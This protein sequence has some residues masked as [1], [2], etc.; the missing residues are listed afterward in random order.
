MERQERACTA[1]RSINSSQ[2]DNMDIENVF[3]RLQNQ[4]FNRALS[5]I[6]CTE[7][8]VDVL[9][10]QSHDVRQAIADL[11]NIHACNGIEDR[12]KVWLDNSRIKLNVQRELAQFPV[13]IFPATKKDSG[14]L[15]GLKP[16]VGPNQGL[17][18]RKVAHEYKLSEVSLSTIKGYSPGSKS[19]QGG[20]K[21]K[22]TLKKRSKGRQ[23][24]WRRGKR[25]R[26]S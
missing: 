5:I 25:G 18:A 12:R 13:D 7:N 1:F 23:E 8:A 16:T 4:I 22:N 24:W 2:L 17:K 26:G 19:F 14:D 6:R 15:L 11:L 3:G 20:T 21:P 10:E 9:K